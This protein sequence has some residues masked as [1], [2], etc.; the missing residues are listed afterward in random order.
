MKRGFWI[1]IL[2][3]LAG[4][5]GFV[6]SRQQCRCAWNERTATQE[7]GSQLPGLEW[8][9]H[10]FGL[11]NEQFT[12]VSELHLAYRP[13]CENL[14]MKV[15]ASHAKVKRLV[16]GG[17]QVSPDLISALKEHAELHVESQTAMLSHLY[18][19]ASCMTPEQARH[20]LDAMLPQVIEMGM[21]P[22]DMSSGH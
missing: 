4:L 19:T 9:R 13:I 21:E 16:G 12:K 1:L 7:R 6:V 3:L 18:R 5:M 14:C 2:S 11:S 20:Y 22:E 15:M 17:T 10:E 8:L